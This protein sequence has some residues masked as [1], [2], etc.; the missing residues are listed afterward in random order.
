MTAT[1]RLAESEIT[2][3]QGLPDLPRQLATRADELLRS[4]IP[5]ADL[6]AG[7][8]PQST[9]PLVILAIHADDALRMPAL[10]H[11]HSCDRSRAPGSGPGNH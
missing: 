2:T 6:L 1:A 5:N 10:V 7:A 3:H 4:G 11:C 9:R 8:G